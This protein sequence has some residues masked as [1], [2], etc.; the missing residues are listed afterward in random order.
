MRIVAAAARTTRAS[1]SVDS[2]ANQRVA[3][4]SSAASSATSVKTPQSWLLPIHGPLATFVATRSASAATAMT[5][6]PG[7][8]SAR[9]RSVSKR[10]VG[11]DCTVSLSAVPATKPL[12]MRRILAAAQSRR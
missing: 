7:L 3:S 2:G 6:V 9:K 4:G 11:C 10:V 5:G 8:S 12:R 1:A